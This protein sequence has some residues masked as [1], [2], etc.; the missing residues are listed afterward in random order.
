MNDL[1]D[2]IQ[3]RPVEQED[4]ET[5]RKYVNDPSIMQFSSP[6]RQISRREQQEWYE[7]L[8]GEKSKYVLAIID[9]EKDLAIGI[10]GLYNIH[11]I[12]RNAQFR[13]RIG[14]QKYHRKGIGTM[15]TQYMVDYAFTQLHLRRVW[16]QVF[17]NNDIAISL[18][19]KV[20]FVKE[21]L[22]RKAAY[23]N[24]QNLNV[25]IMGILME[26]WSARQQ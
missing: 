12:H 4:L 10:V 11:S 1:T 9:P 22:L 24:G 23:I 3:F 25:I 18:Y 5:L 21:G 6:Y 7:S 2:R 16:L 19:E 20:G 13:I 15:A 17:E 8:Q 14:D 26:E